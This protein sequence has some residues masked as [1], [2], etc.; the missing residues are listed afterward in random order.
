MELYDTEEQQV[1]AIKEWW[2][3]NGKAVIV[4]AVV[5]LGGIFGWRFYQDSQA[6]AQNAA[7]LA[8]DGVLKQIQTSGAESSS[9][10]LAF[11]EANKDSQYSVLAALQLAKAFVEAGE[12]D[13]ALEQLSWAKT[14]TK[15]ESIVSLLT[16][17]EARVLAEQEKFDDALTKLDS[18]KEA[19][20]A[21]RIAELRGDILLRQGNTEGAYAAY[22]EAQQQSDTSQALQMKLD[23][24]AK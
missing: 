5:G 2:K 21:G 17:R 18:V 24:L 12:L 10:A 19:G 14:N 1:E 11:I 20:W 4:G 3:E 9:D 15:D 13:K 23:D 22:S 8:Y 6:D 7:S 16:V